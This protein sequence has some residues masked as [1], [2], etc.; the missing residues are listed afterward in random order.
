M[1]PA[2]GVS[3]GPS[4]PLRDDRRC[5]ACMALAIGVVA[6]VGASFAYLGVDWSGMFR[7]ESLR[8]MARFT[9]EFFPPDLQPAFVVKVAWGALQTFAVASVGTL[10]AVVAGMTLALPASG[11]FGRAAR[12]VS[13]LVLN[14]LRSVPELVWAA[15]MVIA[16]GLGPFAGTLA[17]ALHTSGVL[18]RLYA[19]S[20]ENAPRGPEAALR[21]AGSSPVAAFAYSTLPL[22]MPQAL[23]YA[24]Y[25]LEMNIRMAAVLGFVGAGGLGQMLYFHLSIFQQAQAATLL[26]AMLL[27]VFAVDALSGWARSALAPAHG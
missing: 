27:V 12:L 4:P 24:L 19:E 6:A 2:A 1:K 11:R 25:R 21:H 15:L 20:L 14:A 26:I 18:G 17:L 5:T 10:L 23:A 8:L 22:V 7:I 9:A 13:R 16:A 3:P